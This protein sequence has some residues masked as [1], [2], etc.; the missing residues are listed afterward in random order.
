M[1]SR[2][3]HQ[4]IQP[5]SSLINDIPSLAARLVDI[6]QQAKKLGIF[7]NDR[8]LL[9]C[10]QCGLAEDVTCDGRLFTFQSA[11]ETFS[12]TGMRFQEI[13]ATHFRC[14]SCHH[15]LVVTE[16]EEVGNGE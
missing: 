6:H 10:P 16:E 12:D 14:P 4:D 3:K 8:E 1:A 9:K 7:T 15:I 2:K 13:D 5:A 11:D